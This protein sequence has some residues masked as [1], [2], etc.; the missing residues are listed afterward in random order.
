MDVACEARTGAFAQHL[1]RLTSTAPHNDDWTRL[2][3]LPAPF[4]HD[5]HLE[6]DTVTR[7]RDAFAP[8]WCK[9]LGPF[10]NEEGTGNAG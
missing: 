1:K 4:G 9:Q 3:A 2:D 7:S 8:E 6:V 10:E 5:L